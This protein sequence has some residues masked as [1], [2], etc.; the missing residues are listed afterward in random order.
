MSTYGYIKHSELSHHGIK[1]QKW[2]VRRYQ[3][4]DGSLTPEGMKRYYNSDG[5]LTDTAQKM[6]KYYHQYERARQEANTELKF[7]MMG[8]YDGNEKTK[9]FKS[10]KKLYNN[11]PEYRQYVDEGKIIY[12]RLEKQRQDNI[13][14]AKAKLKSKE[15]RNEIVNKSKDKTFV[16]NVIKDTVKLIKEEYNPDQFEK[17]KGKQVYSDDFYDYILDAYTNKINK[18]NSVNRKELS[19]YLHSS[20]VIKE[21]LNNKDNSKLLYDELAKKGFKVID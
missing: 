5:S 21:I 19:K 13:N 16:N 14:N 12:D 20:G 3:N 1:G 18:D 9:Y 7:N 6:E 2:G 15:Y 17:K 4:P 10:L 11:D 8:Y